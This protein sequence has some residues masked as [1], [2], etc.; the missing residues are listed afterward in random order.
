MS[1]IRFLSGNALK[2]IA[3]VTMLIDHIGFMLFP[4]VLILRII[5]RLAFPIFAFMIAEGCKYTRNKLRY[6]LTVASFATV[7]QLVYGFVMNSL[8]MSVFVTFTLAILLVY[9]LQYFKDNLFDPKC[10]S[11]KVAGS[12]LLFAAAVVAVYFLNKY[13]SIDYGFYGCLMPVAASLLHAPKGNNS[14]WLKKLDSIPVHVLTMGLC[15]FWFSYLRG[16]VQMYSLFSLP[17]LMLY[18]GKRGKYKMKYFFYI[19]YPL[20]LVALEGIRMLL[21][22]F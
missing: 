9:L 14:E 8:K 10:N 1:K 22:K 13:V 12:G 11:L 3:A 5:G 21:E 16:W 19:F 20:H 2:I 15:L 17:V 4:R 18:S 7:I 6:F